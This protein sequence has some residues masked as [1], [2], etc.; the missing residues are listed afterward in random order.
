MTEE[1]ICHKPYAIDLSLSEDIVQVCCDAD[2]TLVLTTSGR[3]FGWG[4]N[5]FGEIG[6]SSQEVTKIS[7]PIQL[8]SLESFSIKRIRIGNYCNFAVTTDGWLMSWARYGRQPM[9]DWQPWVITIFK[10]VVDIC[11]TVD[12]T[13]ML[14]NDGNVDTRPSLCFLGNNLPHFLALTYQNRDFSEHPLIQTIESY[15]TSIETDSKQGD[16]TI[17]IKEVHA[18]NEVVVGLSEDR[19]Y[20]ISKFYNKPH[21][22]TKYKTFFDF[23]MDNDKLMKTT[24]IHSITKKSPCW[25]NDDKTSDFKIK[26]R[27]IDG[28][29]EHIYCHKS[30]LTEKSNYFERMFAINWSESNDNEMEVI[31]HSIE[32]FYL[33]IRWLYT[34]CIATQ[35]IDLLIQML[36]ISDQYLDNKF[37]DKI[38]KQLRAQTN[39]EN[40]CSLYGLSIKL[41]FKAFQDICW[42]IIT[43]NIEKVI[44]TEDFDSLDAELTKHLFREYIRKQGFVEL[45]TQRL[46]EGNIVI[47]TG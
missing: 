39:V 42:Q 30:V 23:Y 15:R 46:T 47:K 14:T 11:E 16:Q 37:K 35:D 31:G 9:D 34:D 17:V 25:F 19:I 36:S 44:E 29:Y 7:V 21:I 5:Q 8:K 38:L 24:M 20:T 33:Y 43:E 28:N 26:I 22:R 12:T 32:A 2:H 4:R 1:G 13:Y 3:V 10:G 18:I 41:N 40:V 6:L 45:Y 27:G